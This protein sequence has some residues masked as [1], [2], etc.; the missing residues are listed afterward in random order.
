[1]QQ[2]VDLI[3][4]DNN[5]RA[6]C[7]NAVHVALSEIKASEADMRR[8]FHRRSKDAKRRRRLRTAISDYRTL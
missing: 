4:P 2:A 6:E 8:M 3:G 1:M 7:V 5:R